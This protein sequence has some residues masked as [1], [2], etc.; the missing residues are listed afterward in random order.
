MGLPA[1][2]SE[3][4]VASRRPHLR[5]VRS[6]TSARPTRRSSHAFAYQM[7]VFFAVV[8]CVVAVLGLGR[9]WLSVQA[10]QASIDCG[11]LQTAIKAARYE[12]DM[13]EIQ[14]SALATPSRVQA[15]A[16]GTMGM[17]PATSVSYLRLEAPSP[18]TL[19]VAEDQEGAGA[20]VRAAVFNKLVDVAAAEARLLLVGDVGLASSK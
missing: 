6:K 1:L 19:V 18:G 17:G 5:V 16:I 9:V 11:K 10:A 20:S 13:L 15:I 2:K 8:V 14:E 12:G 7:F 3:P 4:Q